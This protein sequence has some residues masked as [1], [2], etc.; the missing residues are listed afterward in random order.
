LKFA[1]NM[2]DITKYATIINGINLKIVKNVFISIY[3]TLTFLLCV[4]IY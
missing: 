3:S 2:P 4:N 1:S